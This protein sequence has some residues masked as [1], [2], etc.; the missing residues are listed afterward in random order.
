MVEGAADLVKALRARMYRFHGPW[1]AW[2]RPLNAATAVVFTPLLM[3]RAGEWVIPC[4]FT[5]YRGSR[6]V[7]NLTGFRVLDPGE[8]VFPPTADTLN[9]VS[10]AEVVINFTGIA[11]NTQET[12]PGHLGLMFPTARI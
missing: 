12:P 10:A 3:G 6:L 8:T 2:G 7:F 9:L 4:P 1:C 11:D 5:T